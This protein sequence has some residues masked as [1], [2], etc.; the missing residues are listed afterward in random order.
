MPGIALVELIYFQLTLV[1]LMVLTFVW[2]FYLMKK[3]HHFEFTRTWKQMLLFFVISLIL[4]LLITLYNYS[5]VKVV[6]GHPINFRE[7][8]EICTRLRAHIDEENWTHMLI[9]YEVMGTFLYLLFCISII[10]LK[11]IQDIL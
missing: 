9:S 4:F 10:T 11:S 5:L 7:L 6:R 8:D 3:Y 2:M 1:V